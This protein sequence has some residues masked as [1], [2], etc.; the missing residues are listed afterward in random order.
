MAL[1]NPKTRTTFVFKWY[2]NHLRGDLMRSTVSS[3]FLYV[4]SSVCEGVQGRV[5]IVRNFDKMQEN[6]TK[7]LAG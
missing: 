1:F 3:C 6:A 5:A 2:F 4:Q 7:S